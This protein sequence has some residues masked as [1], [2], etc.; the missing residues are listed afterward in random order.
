MQ[1]K[2]DSYLKRLKNDDQ[3]LKDLL[4][5]ILI[6]NPSKRSTIEEILAHEYFQEYRNSP[7][8]NMKK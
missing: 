7:T 5:K 8:Y 2:V 6:L 1:L 4:K 3:S